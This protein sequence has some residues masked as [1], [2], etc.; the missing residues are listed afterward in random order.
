MSYVADVTN[1]PDFDEVDQS[2]DN[3]MKFEKYSLSEIYRELHVKDSVY[4]FT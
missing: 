2:R 1:Y 3:F 4:T